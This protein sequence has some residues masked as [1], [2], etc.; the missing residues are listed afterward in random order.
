M[1]E[2]QGFETMV[3]MDLYIIY[4]YGVLFHFHT[5]VVFFTE[6]DSLFKSALNV[7]SS[8]YFSSE[9]IETSA[10]NSANLTTRQ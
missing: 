5:V 3:I 4:I 9:S 2:F 7:L 6:L 8:V 1:A 10:A